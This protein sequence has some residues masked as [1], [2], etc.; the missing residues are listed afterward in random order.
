MRKYYETIRKNSE[1]L[2][3][4][5]AEVESG[6]FEVVEKTSD[7][8]SIKGLTD[9][10][11]VNSVLASIREGGEVIHVEGIGNGDYLVNS[12]GAGYAEEAAKSLCKDAGLK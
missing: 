1:D 4:I 6:K 8:G 3:K 12:H 7:A 5:I 2:Y 10:L 9:A 11:R